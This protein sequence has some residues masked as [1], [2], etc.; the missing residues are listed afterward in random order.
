MIERLIETDLE[1][2]ILY[3]NTRNQE[4][5]SRIVD[6]LTHV[7]IHGAYHRGQIARVVGLPRLRREYGL[8]HVRLTSSRSE[9]FERGWLTPAEPW[10]YN[11]TWQ[12]IARMFR[13]RD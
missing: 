2:S 12:L 6:I 7:V 3:R 13:G 10:Q 8:H 11:A 4:F 9:R 1:K 5:T